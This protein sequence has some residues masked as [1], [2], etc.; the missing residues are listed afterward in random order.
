MEVPVSEATKK[1]IT[2]WR[3]LMLAGLGSLILCVVCLATLPNAI[4]A[5]GGF[6][7]FLFFLGFIGL[8][9]LGGWKSDVVGADVDERS[10]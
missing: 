10:I 2:N 9:I 8:V 4:G 3:L 7:G 6:L 1:L 5:F